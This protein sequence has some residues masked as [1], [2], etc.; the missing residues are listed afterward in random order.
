[1][2]FIHDD[3]SVDDLLTICQVQETPL[4]PYAVVP[5]QQMPLGQV[6]VGTAVSNRLSCTDESHARNVA[7]MQCLLTGLRTWTG[8][9]RL[10]KLQGHAQCSGWIGNL[11]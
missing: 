3:K 2:K 7:A 8:S 5:A 6:I 10:R 11:L 9:E 1:M 4:D